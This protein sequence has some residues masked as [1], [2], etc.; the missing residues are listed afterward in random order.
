MVQIVAYKLTPQAKEDL[1]GIM[2]YT[3]D[4]WGQSQTKAYVSGLKTTFSKL[5]FSPNIGKNIDFVRVGYQIFFYKKHVIFYRMT[6]CLEVVRIINQD[7]DYLK[8]LI[9]S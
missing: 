1:L 7:Q 5:E 9:D 6:D 8:I 2:I 4:V 3:L